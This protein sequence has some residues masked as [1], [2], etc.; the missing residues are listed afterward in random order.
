MRLPAGGYLA[1]MSFLRSEV[2]LH[3]P[4]EC[5]RQRS[6]AAPP[7]PPVRGAGRGV[8]PLL[9]AA[10]LLTIV[11]ALA[12]CGAGDPGRDAHPTGEDEVVLR[13]T[14]GGGLVPIE[15][16]FSLVPEFSLYGGGR[17]VVPGPVDAI[18][19][20]AALP[21]LQTVVVP[22]ESLQSILS[23][24]REAGLFDPS[25]D[26]GLP[27]VADGPTT[28]IVIDAGGSIHR[29]EIY[30]LTIEGAGGLSLEQQQA[31]AAVND[32]RS[33]L[34][35]LAAFVSGPIAW[36]QYQFS[37]LAV[38]TQAVDAGDPPDVQPNYLEWPLGDLST[39]G[40]EASR[41]GSRR[42]VV[43]GKDLAALRPL[44]DKATQI[45]IWSSGGSQYH[46]VFRPLL[47]DEKS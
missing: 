38:Y 32:A 19:P 28:T 22:E 8:R 39:L 7:W 6:V 18:Y 14:T 1:G 42:V 9:A 13:M 12:A 27:T 30:A 23:A 16:D 4:A 34:I 46:L 43:S 36:E 29:S 21:N 24:A 2:D 26:Y 31:R 44:L 47:P 40:E 25:F 35:D 5:V 37:G 20:G 45:T 33:K 11:L 15:Y 3:T 10:A 17:V 41:P